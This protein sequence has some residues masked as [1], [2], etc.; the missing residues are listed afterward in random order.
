MYEAAIWRC[1]S[2]D[3]KVWNIGNSKFQ[4]GVNMNNKCE[5]VCMYVQAPGDLSR[6]TPC[7]VQ[8]MLGDDSAPCN[9]LIINEATE[10]I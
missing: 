10:E 4:A 9:V 5:C 7:L 6:C 8:C 3:I 2:K 1:M